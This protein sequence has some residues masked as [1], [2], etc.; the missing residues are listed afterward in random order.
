VTT[1]EAPGLSVDIVPLDV[2]ALELAVLVPLALVPS[3]FVSMVLLHALVTTLG[4]TPLVTTLLRM[5][6]RHGHHRD[7]ESTERNRQQRTSH[8][9]ASLARATTGRDIVVRSAVATAHS[10]LRVITSDGC[11]K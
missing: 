8:L 3:R 1:L 9:T 4:A 7:G 5:E 10:S 6:R 2:V 11:C